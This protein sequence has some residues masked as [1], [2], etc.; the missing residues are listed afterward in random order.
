M[1]VRSLMNAGTSQP[2]FTSVWKV[3]V[4]SPIWTLQAPIS[5]MAQETGEPPV[6]SRSRTQKV[7][8]VKGVPNSS[9]DRCTCMVGD[10]TE[11]M[12]D[13]SRLCAW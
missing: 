3:P 10:D 12:F 7:T 1:P 4:T 8:S 2:G 11:H 13:N 9:K 5:V 6:V